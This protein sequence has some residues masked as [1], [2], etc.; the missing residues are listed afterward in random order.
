[1]M[2][3]AVLLRS[4]YDFFRDISISSVIARES[5]RYYKCMCDI[6]RSENGG[7]LTYFLQY[8]LELL[9]R[10]LDV[11][12]ERQRKREQE[13]REREQETLRQEKELARKP[14]TPTVQ[15]CDACDYLISHRLVHN[16]STQQRSA[17]YVFSHLEEKKITDP[18]EPA[19]PPAETLIS[20]PGDPPSKALISELQEMLTGVLGERKKNIASILL[21]FIEKGVYSFRTG[22]VMKDFDMPK[23]TC[24]STLRTAVNLGFLHKEPA[25]R[26][27]CHYLYVINMKRTTGIRGDALTHKQKE[28]LTA[29]YQ[30]FKSW[31]FSVRD[32]T[33]VVPLQENSLAFH[34]HNFAQCGIL[35]VRE[36]AGRADYY[37][38]AVTPKRNP[39]CFLAE[40]S[41]VR[42]QSTS[43]STSAVIPMA[44]ASA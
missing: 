12:N 3:S 11:R 43:S 42:A 40:P 34:L 9:V 41:H 4:G 13:A 37:T 31:E 38:F 27:S 29:L 14:L 5:Y 32:G 30:K 15:P 16:V 24:I 1:M 33:K 22:T 20:E 35:T 21:S 2:S 6:I 23:S 39:D 36:G 7:D 18:S 28:I 19:G 44:A 8:Y 17:V 10:A 25:R 26:E